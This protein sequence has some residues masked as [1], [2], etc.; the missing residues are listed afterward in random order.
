ALRGGRVRD[1]LAIRRGPGAADDA[2]GQGDAAVRD[3]AGGAGCR[4]GVRRAWLPPGAATPCYQREREGEV[5]RGVEAV[6]WGF[7]E[8]VGD[9]SAAA[10]GG[11]FDFSGER[12]GLRL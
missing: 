6:G 2:L 12:P 7:L 8:G 11:V 4:G 10:R 1:R 3:R 5:A 9:D